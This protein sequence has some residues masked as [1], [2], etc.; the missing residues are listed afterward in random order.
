[1]NHGDSTKIPF[2][3]KVRRYFA[4]LPVDRFALKMLDFWSLWENQGSHAVLGSPSV[5]SGS[6]TVGSGWTDQ[7]CAAILDLFHRQRQEIPVFGRFVEAVKSNASAIRYP[8]DLV[9]LPIEAFKEHELAWGPPPSARQLFRS[10]GTSAGVQRRSVHSMAYPD[11][12]WERSLDFAQTILGPLDGKALL[13]LLPSY[14]DRGESSLLAML[15]FYM[16]ASDLVQGSFYNKDYN[17]FTR[18][19]QQAQLNQSP[20]LAWGIPHALLEW[21]QET[22]LVP[23]SSDI[24]METGGSKGMERTWTE[25][26]RRQC[27]RQALGSSIRLG[28]EYGMTE[29]GSQAYRLDGT[30]WE[31]YVFPPMVGVGFYRTDNP[32]EWEKAGGIGGLNM[33]D[34]ANYYSVSF[35]QTRDLGRCLP[36]GSLELLGRLDGAEPRGC[37]LLHVQ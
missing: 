13:A 33:V 8:E 35:I 25:A 22:D 31:G 27:W 32:L 16:E 15:A 12:V 7:Q 17:A 36:D 34:P 14:M 1:V 20:V 10:S 6:S 4:L 28:G 5:G 29:L 18:D 26:E 30:R 2:L 24:L 11:L 19:W 21:I 9:F 37:N 23:S 3:E